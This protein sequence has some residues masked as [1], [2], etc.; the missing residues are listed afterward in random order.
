MTLHNQIDPFCAALQQELADLSE[1]AISQDEPVAL[2]TAMAT[3]YTAR[4]VLYDMHVTSNKRGNNSR[5][6]HEMEKTAKASLKATCFAIHAFA[7][8]I[9]RSAEMG[10]MLRMSPFVGDCLYQAVMI[11]GWLMGVSEPEEELVTKVM[12]IKSALRVVG[13]RWHVA[14]KSILFPLGG[15]NAGA[16]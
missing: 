8:R 1:R 4:L 3:C 2:F 5:A 16:A 9:S 11:F 13:R 12:D 15:A 7:L 14:S 6:Q 10:G